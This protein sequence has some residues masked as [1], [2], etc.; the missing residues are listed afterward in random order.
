M[1]SVALT[2]KAA[3]VRWW[4]E[5]PQNAFLALSLVPV[6][7]RHSSAL[8]NLSQSTLLSTASLILPS[9]PLLALV[10]TCLFESTAHSCFKSSKRGSS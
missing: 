3:D 8:G 9:S 2:K 6:E 4:P 5:R 10:L 7:E 1:R